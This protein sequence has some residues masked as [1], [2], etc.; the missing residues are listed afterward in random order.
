MSLR[1]ASAVLGLLALTGSAA[2]HAAAATQSLDRVRAVAEQALRDHYSRPG[3]RVVVRTEPLDLR[4]QLDAC[5]EPLR[6]RVA[7][8]AP[9]RPRMTVPVQCPQPGGWT[10]RVP[11]HLQVFRPVLVSSRALLRGDGIGAADVH[12]EERDVTRL[13]YGYLD[14]LDQVAGR[15][16]SRALARGSVLS[17]GALGGR[18]M[19][20]AGDHVQVLAQLEGIEVRAEGVALGSGDNGARLRV[21]NAASGRVIDAMVHAPGVV[22]AL[23]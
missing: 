14:N 7:E 20:R 5:A 15:S 19:V 22:V 23:P 9:P 12:A 8:Q 3:S 16:L 21:R 6:A 1:A 10:V 18:R 17:P 13:G 2:V 4:L 11:V